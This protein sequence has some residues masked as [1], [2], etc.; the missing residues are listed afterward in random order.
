MKPLIM[1]I[2]GIVALTVFVAGAV[3]SGAPT[4]KAPAG[5]SIVWQTDFDKALATA[6]KQNKL[7]MVDF[8]TEN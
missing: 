4:G 3:A 6:K 2:A 5:K 7:L 1:R 8:Y